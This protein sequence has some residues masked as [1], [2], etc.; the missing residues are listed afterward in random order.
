MKRLLIIF[1][2]DEFKKLKK[3]K[4]KMTWHEYILTLI[5]GD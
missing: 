5:E 1:D 4:G 2:N 3:A